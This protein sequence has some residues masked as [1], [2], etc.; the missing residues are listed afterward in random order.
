MRTFVMAL[1]TLAAGAGMMC[2]QP[3]GDPEER[4]PRLVMYDAVP[5]PADSGTA[6]VRIDVHYR[7]DR[8]FFVPVKNSDGDGEKPFVRRG[9]VLV[10]LMDST[11]TAAAR[12]LARIVVGEENEE[13]IPEGHFWE[14][15]ILSFTVRPGSY[16]IQISVDDLESRR[17]F[18]EKTRM[19]TAGEPSRTGLGS[20]STMFLAGAPAEPVLPPSVAP[21]N[22]GGDLVFGVPAALA[23]L[24]QPRGGG[25]SIL[26]VAVSFHQVPADEN[27]ELFLPTSPTTK[28]IIHRGVSLRPAADA[29]GIRYLV[30]GG[31]NTCLALIPFPAERFL[32]R[33]FSMNISLSAGLETHTLT[34]SFR[35]MW[36]DMPFSLKDVD[37]ALAALKYITTEDEL[38][39]LRKGNYETRRGNLEGFWRKRDARPKSALNDVEAEYYRRVDFAARNFGT[40][41]QPDGFHSDRGK[42][43]ILFGPPTTTDRSLD[44]S[45]GF[46][47]IWTYSKLN[48]RFTFVDPNKTGNYVLQAGAP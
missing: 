48:R 2:A 10:E 1:V 9:E 35:I 18:T 16:T 30:R 41:R 38:D 3:R 45:T 13:R 46:Q 19:V 14:Q 23:V 8:A 47:E 15:G 32:L 44:P 39:S 20:A 42:V 33:A 21:T 29:G 5:L 22:M 11:W 37:Y 40:L 4:G 27:D 31:G 28:A 34:R 17:N 25:D 36:P 6:V 12:S 7:I 43:Y 26:T 24:W